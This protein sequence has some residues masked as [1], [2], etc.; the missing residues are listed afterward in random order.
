MTDQT[1]YSEEEKQSQFTIDE[2]DGKPKIKP[3]NSFLHG[4]PS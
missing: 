2:E 4:Q 3:N 1:P